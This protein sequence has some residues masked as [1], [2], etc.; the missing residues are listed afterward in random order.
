[1]DNPAIA[2]AIKITVLRDQWLI[3]Y[4]KPNKNTKTWIKKGVQAK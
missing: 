1:M 4:E 3:Q 2:K